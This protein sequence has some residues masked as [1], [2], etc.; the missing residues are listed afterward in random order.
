[1]KQ[2]KTKKNEG[3]ENETINAYEYTQR[4]VRDRKSVV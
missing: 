1:M 2:K 3:K 4:M